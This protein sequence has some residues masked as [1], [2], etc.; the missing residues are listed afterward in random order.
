[1]KLRQLAEKIGARIL[2]DADLDVSGVAGVSSAK[3]SEIVFAEDEENFAAALKSQASAVIAG[4]FA[5]K[6]S[7]SKAVLIAGNPR[8][9]FARAASLL[10]GSAARST[11]VHPSAVIDTSA[12]LGK[13]VSVGANAA[14][15]Q[16]S[17]GERTRVGAGC[18]VGDG[19][20]L[21]ADCEIYP[22]V[23]IYPG[24][25]LGNRVIVHAGAV[26]GSDGFGYVSDPENG[27]HEKFPQIG[28][29]EIGD[30]VEIG[31][32][33]TID[34]GALETTRIG[35]GTKIDNLVHIGHNCKFGE[36]VIIAAQAGFSGSITIENNVVIG[37]QVGVGEH[38]RIQEGVLLGGQAG[39]L[40]KKILR[41]KGVAFWG[42]PAKPLRE[43]LR[44]LGSLARL[45]KRE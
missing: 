11:G 33:T 12:K 37:G 45:G 16:S 17:I 23:T 42:T 20:E 26:L 7:S 25:R 8:L 13:G 38:A 22:N 34:R 6:V 2:G 1:M 41:G 40:P 35:R 28:K 4:S 29:L 15:G 24:S 3:S 32:N 27:R 18:V 30:D 19:V 5:E 43:Y 14:I 21:G 9:A 44:S 10:R 36:D 31:A 39:V